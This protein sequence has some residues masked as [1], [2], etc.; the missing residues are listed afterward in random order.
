MAGALRFYTLYSCSIQYR[1]EAGYVGDNHSAWWEWGLW[2]LFCLSPSLSRDAAF[3]VF[4]IKLLE[5]HWSGV[6]GTCVQE[7]VWC[8][9]TNLGTIK[10]GNEPRPKTFTKTIK[11]NWASPRQRER[12]ATKLGIDNKKIT[13]IPHQ[14]I[15]FFC[16]SFEVSKCSFS[17]GFQQTSHFLE[18]S[19]NSLKIVVGSPSL[20]QRLFSI[21][22]GAKRFRCTSSLPIPKCLSS[23]WYQTLPPGFHPS[24]S[25]NK[26]LKNP[27]QMSLFSLIKL[28]MAFT[29]AMWKFSK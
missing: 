13:L 11:H 14:Y 2:F 25:L 4:R 9:P 27:E 7:P 17:R 23:H 8:R 18:V 20:R 10:A 15:W 19:P 29:T 16:C 24:Q 21:K 22:D 28:C 3:P 6:W 26:G 5:H 12:Q 1:S